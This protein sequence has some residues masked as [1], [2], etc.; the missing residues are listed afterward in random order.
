MLPL[1]DEMPTRR[2]PIVTL[3]LIL[4]NLLALIFMLGLEVSDESKANRFVYK[5]SVVP[6]EITNG[7]HVD[8]EELLKSEPRP[9]ARG[10]A[11]SNPYGKN[12]YLSLLTHIFLHGGFLHLL[13]NMWFLWFFGSKVEE[14][15]GGL[16]FLLFYLLCGVVAALSQWAVYTDEVVAMVGASGAVSGVMGAYLVIYP[17]QKVFSIIFFWPAWVPAWAFLLAWFAYQ[18]LFG[19]ISQISVASGG[20]AWFAHIGG[21]AAGALAALALYPWLGRRRDA[22]SRVHVPVYPNYLRKGP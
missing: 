9:P 21:L 14:V 15:F 12:V 13:G 3:T 10:E 4:T 2:L 6:W 11:D 22:L 16:P 5:Y 1:F 18:A 19:L 20:T 17:R 8:Y 7:R